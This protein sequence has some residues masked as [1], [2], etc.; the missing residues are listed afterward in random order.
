MK[1]TK[2]QQIIVNEIQKPECNFLKV[3]AKSGSGK[4]A[5]L[6]QIAKVIQPKNGIYLAFSKHIATE[7]SKKFPKNVACMTTHSLAY[8]N[9]VKPLNLNVGWFNWKDIKRRVKYLHKLLIIDVVND[10][11]LSKFTKFDDFVAWHKKNE[12]DMTEA[13]PNIYKF[14]HEAIKD[15]FHGKIQITHSG[16]LKMYHM[17]LHAEKMHHKEFDLIMLDEAQDSAPV[18]LEIFKLLPAKKK[19]MVGDPFQSIFSFNKCVNGFDVLRNEGVSKEMTQT[20]RCNPILAEQVQ[21]FMQRY[22]DPDF[23]F[24]G[25][26]PVDDVIRTTMHIARTNSALVLKI[27]EL[28]NGGVR[29]NM[30][31]EAD[32]IFELVLIL[33]Y[34]KPGGRI[35]SQEWKYLQEDIDEWDNDPFLKSEYKTILSYM[36]EK[37][38]EEPG[39]KSALGIIGTHGPKK[40][41]EAHAFAKS[42]EGHKNHAIT[43]GTAHSL[44]GAEADKVYIMDD[45]NNSIR[46]L[47]EEGKPLYEYTEADKEAINVVYTAYTRA[48]KQL[49]NAE[50]L[51]PL[52]PAI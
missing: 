8:Q 3:E 48:S 38:G 47:I 6:I 9:T 29:F 50:W 39:I 10:F 37:Y 1:L 16:Y 32:K 22:A 41:I 15:M 27:I 35:F 4:T 44:K 33:I 30:A 45:L 43:I 21:E 36:S 14:A 40:V 52:T 51:E 25:T 34:A 7:A 11:F 12:I 13:N 2:E 20:F 42:H 19:V 46:D 24:V 49:I 23:H 17:M 5:T 31:R 26:K 18:T 28:M